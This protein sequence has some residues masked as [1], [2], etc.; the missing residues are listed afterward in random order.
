[1]KTQPL[2]GMNL[3]ETAE[4]LGVCYRTLWNWAHQPN[5]IPHLRIGA[6]YLFQEEEVVAWLKQ[7]QEDQAIRDKKKRSP[8]R[9]YFTFC[10]RKR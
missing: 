10:R 3:E 5:P 1:M 4:F 9:K 8:G 6:K 7:R 2:E